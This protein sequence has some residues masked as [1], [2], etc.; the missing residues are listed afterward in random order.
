MKKPNKKP[1][2]MIFIDPN[3]IGLSPRTIKRMAR[4]FLE[5]FNRNELITKHLN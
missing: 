5:S 4:K 3:I 1:G 2:R